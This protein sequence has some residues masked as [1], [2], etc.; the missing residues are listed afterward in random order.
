MTSE[1]KSPIRAITIEE[2]FEFEFAFSPHS[3]PKFSIREESS[4]GEFFQEIRHQKKENLIQLS[5]LRA[6]V[7]TLDL[8]VQSVL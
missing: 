6:Y 1:N 4:K 3:F 5:H 2:I 8:Q 7:K